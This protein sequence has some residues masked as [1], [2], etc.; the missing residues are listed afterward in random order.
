MRATGSQSSRRLPSPWSSTIGS[1]W[2]NAAYGVA[3]GGASGRAL[4]I[5]SAST[6]ST[7]TIWGWGRRTPSVI[8]G[9]GCELLL[10]LRGEALG[11]EVAD[12]GG[13][14]V[15]LLLHD[16]RPAVGN[17]P[18]QHSRGLVVAQG[19]GQRRPLQAR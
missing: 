6:A 5:A 17:P 11:N 19:L 14:R 18:R 10:L 12:R 15:G 1:P 7:T 9:S 16:E 2:P 13:E 4:A 8:G 3:G